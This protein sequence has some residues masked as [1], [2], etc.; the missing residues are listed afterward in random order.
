MS[1]QPAS[2]DTKNAV[3]DILS[4]F[5]S[6]YDWETD[7]HLATLR[8]EMYGKYGRLG[9]VVDAH[10]LHSMLRQCDD[11]TMMDQQLYLYL[12][13]TE[14][15][16]LLPLVTIQSSHSWVHF[17]IYALLTLLD[18]SMELQSLAIRFETDER[19]FEQ[20]SSIGSHDFCHAQFCN[21][22][23]PVARATTPKW[24]PTSQPSFPLNADDQVSLVLCMLT[25]LYGGA[26]VLNRFSAAG[27]K[28]LREYLDKVRALKAPCQPDE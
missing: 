27:D 16:K 21:E 8:D 14:D 2:E 17:R 3:S 7:G 10:R 13:P 11:V 12:E 20:S 5:L 1:I 22:I 9:P 26:R 4:R 24:L 18:D 15:K 19:F 6:S 25:S 23:D 28:D